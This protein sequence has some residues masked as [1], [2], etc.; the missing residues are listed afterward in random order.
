MLS[1]GCALERLYFL[2]S[3]NSD[4]VRRDQC[5]VPL[6]LVPADSPRCFRHSFVAC[7]PFSNSQTAHCTLHMVSV[8]RFFAVASLLVKWAALM[9]CSDVISSGLPI[10]VDCPSREDLTNWNMSAW[11]DGTCFNTQSKLGMCGLS[12]DAVDIGNEKLITPSNLAP[13]SNIPPNQKSEGAQPPPTSDPK[14]A[15][16]SWVWVVVAICILVAVCKEQSRKTLSVAEIKY[17]Q[18]SVGARFQ[19]GRPLRETI[20]Q[21]RRGKE[22]FPYIRVVEYE[23]E[24]YSLDN[25]RLHCLKEA[26]RWKPHQQV[27]VI[28]ESLDDPKIRREFEGKRTPGHSGNSATVRGRM[29][30]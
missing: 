12:E 9:K 5:L 26:Y 1:V 10:A 30:G 7:C 29:Y 13:S 4:L 22:G 8:L 15:E 14:P 19:D 25:R 27:S 3:R 17:T 23:N 18:S 21:I 16:T 2:T 20:Q 24:Y 28:I 6:P 11:A